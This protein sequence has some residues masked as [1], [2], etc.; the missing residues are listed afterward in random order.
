MK[1]WVSHVG[2]CVSD[3]DRSLRFYT[4]GLG[5]EV[6]ER[7]PGDDAWAALAEVTP[8]VSMISQFIAKGDARLELLAFPT[9]GV[10]GQPSATRNQLGLTHLCIGVDDLDEVEAQLV[11]LGAKV[12]ERVRDELVEQV[13]VEQ[14]PRLEGRQMVMVIAPK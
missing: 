2:L 9:P 5:F 14:W 13:K 4:E 6:Q 1:T 8:P 10:H 7:I 3:L 12:L 11:G